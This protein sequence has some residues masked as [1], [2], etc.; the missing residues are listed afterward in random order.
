[1]KCAI[2]IVSYRADLHWL[3]YCLRFIRKNWKEPGTPIYVRLEHDCRDV[4][5]EWQAPGVNYIFVDPWPDGYARQMYLK[6]TW[7]Q[8]LPSDIDLVILVD[9]DLMLV[10]PCFL[11]DLLCD[12][13]PVIDWLPWTESWDAERAWRAVTSLAMGMDLK[14]DMMVSAPFPLWVSTIAA[15]RAHIER[16]IRGSLEKWM[17]SDVVFKTENFLTHPLKLADYEAMNLYASTYEANR[18]VLRNCHDRPVPWPWR[19]YWS[20]GDWNAAL[21]AEFEQKLGG[22]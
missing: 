9:S 21:Q 18:Y 3:S 19:L 17:Y 1:M 2:A 16:V 7:D 12:G 15:T 22:Y 14:C 13:K 11:D 4:V 20:R 8:D 5:A 10:R 6:L